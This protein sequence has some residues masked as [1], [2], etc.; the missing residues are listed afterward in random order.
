VKAEAENRGVTVVLAFGATWGMPLLFFISGMG[1]CY[2]LRS[3]S[4]TAF[5]R[6]RLRRPGVPMAIG[7]L[8][9][10]PLQV[11]LELPVAQEAEPTFSHAAS[12][13]NVQHKITAHTHKGQRGPRSGTTRRVKGRFRCDRDGRLLGPVGRQRASPVSQ[14]RYEHRY[15]PL[16]GPQQM[17]R[18]TSP[19]RCGPTRCGGAVGG[20]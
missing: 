2:A 17:K 7:L 18:R 9:L 6:E 19:K 11:Y 14:D 20:G 10:V 3:R 1:I 13:R 4:A 8:T 12:S 15:P 5:A 16:H